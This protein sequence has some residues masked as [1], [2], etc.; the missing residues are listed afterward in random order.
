ML[1]SNPRI[2]SQASNFYNIGFTVEVEN[3]PFG[4]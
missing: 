1:G 3:E 2:L 4:I